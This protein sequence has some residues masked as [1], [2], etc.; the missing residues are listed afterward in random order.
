MDLTY[1]AS[2]KSLY[3]TSISL[4]KFKTGFTS[5]LF[6]ATYLL[7]AILNYFTSIATSFVGIALISV[8]DPCILL[9]S[10]SNFLDYDLYTLNES[11]SLFSIL[12]EVI[13][14]GF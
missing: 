8:R 2:N 14:I 1:L 3:A 10:R 13:A 4:S 6:P 7:L 9:L 11:R 12:S 5:L